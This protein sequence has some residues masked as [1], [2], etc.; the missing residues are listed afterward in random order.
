MPLPGSTG[1]FTT[2]F[3]VQGENADP[4]ASNDSATATV[5]VIAAA[6][7]AVTIEPGVGGPY[8]GSTWTYTISVSNLGLSDATGVTV[9]SPVPSQLQFPSV[10]SSQGSQPQI[11]NGIISALLGTIPAGKTAAVTVTVLPGS[12]ASYALTASVAGNQYDP[13]PANN[14]TT[15]PIGTAA[16][17][18][19]AVNLVPPSSGVE[20]GQ[21][22]S[23]TAWVQ[24]NGP[25][26]ATDVLLTIPVAGG[27]VYQ[28][29]T[30][31][32]GTMTQSGGQL[33]AHIGQVDPG[34]SASVTVWVMAPAPGTITQTA[35]VA[36]AENQ[37]EGGTLT[38][39]TTV[40]VMESPGILQFSNSTVSVSENA[41]LAQFVVTR[42][43]GARGAVSIGYQAVSAGAIPGLDFTPVSGTLSFAADQTSAMI[44]VPVL[45]NKWDNHDE[46][47]SVVLGS[48][49]GGATLGPQGT[50][51][52]RI[53][54]IDPNRTPPQ[55]SGLTWTG[56]ASSI[57]S[58]NVSFS[59]P[60][61]PTSALN[62]A[63]YQL[64]APGLGNRIIPLT[65]QSYSGSGY[66]VT[67]VPSVALPSGQYYYIQIIGAG[68]AGIHDIA[69]NSLDGSG[70]GRSGTNYQASF[71]QGKRL[72]YLDASGNRVSLKLAGSGY[73]EQVRDAS[74]E[75]VL[76]QLVGISPHHAT[77]SGTVKKGLTRA[78]R[79]R[80]SARSTNLGAI[81][82]L[83][84]FGDVKVLLTSPPF[85]VTSYPFQRR[86]KALL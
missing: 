7:L 66:S 18:K 14:Q 23:F 57:T 3:S 37:L 85:F 53:I 82:G 74:G 44:Q 16:S 20:S 6:D 4:D 22:W 64:V 34:S 59:A 73:L 35:S 58:L 78:L 81:G 30:P 49:T 42:T 11:Q 70:L 46:F 62:Q 56:S 41:G 76:L 47:V 54:D 24:N 71:A 1:Q 31:S 86:G 61:D 43:D 21:D 69:G 45:A 63:N 25:D 48:P 27:L 8:N 60:L 68:P 51:L 15:L 83:G 12:V 28:S 5:Q 79:G 32:K 65:P 38:A 39:S 77:L 17:A 52:L 2:A 55:V 36:C 9:S 19:L 80:G 10:T 50:A 75:G 26:P 13:N 40:S 84:N 33:S 67:L 29:A 72:Q